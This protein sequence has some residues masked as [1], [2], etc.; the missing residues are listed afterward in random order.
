MAKIFNNPKLT[1]SNAGDNYEI[2][3]KSGD[4][5]NAMFIYPKDDRKPYFFID[6][7]NEEIPIKDVI[8][9]RKKVYQFKDKIIDAS[10]AIQS[11]D[12][13]KDFLD[14]DD[15]KQAINILADIFVSSGEK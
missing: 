10:L 14:E 9:W 5:L 3:I 2:L 11:G 1:E 15:I 6:E 7:T 8:F 12:P 4:L 13:L